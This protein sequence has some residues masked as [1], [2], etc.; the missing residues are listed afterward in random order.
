VRQEKSAVVTNDAELGVLQGFMPDDALHG[1]EELKPAPSDP[2]VTPSLSKSF[3]SVSYR[4]A[5]AS[6]RQQQSTLPAKGVCW[7]LALVWT[8]IANEVALQTQRL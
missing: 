1:T 5:S 6:V 3:R 2:A 4:R 8:S 7:T